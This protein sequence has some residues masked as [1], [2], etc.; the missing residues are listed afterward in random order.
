MRLRVHVDS[1]CGAGES[2]KRKEKGFVEIE[3]SECCCSLLILRIPSSTKHRFLITDCGRNS[4]PQRSRKSLSFS[5][6]SSKSQPCGISRPTQAT[7]APMEA[8]RSE[9][10]TG[11]SSPPMKL[12]FVE[13]GVGYDQ[14]GCSIRFPFWILAPLLSLPSLF[15]CLFIYLFISLQRT[16]QAEHNGCGNEGMQ[17]CHFF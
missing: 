2:V 4:F 8:E 12:L 11:S 10:S 9:A 14:H 3:M 17:G 15:H 7:T 6:R 13:M 16:K 5:N 1:I